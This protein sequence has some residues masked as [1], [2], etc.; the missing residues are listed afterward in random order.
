MPSARARSP[1][2]KT[3]ETIASDSP[4]R[5]APPT[6]CRTRPATSTSSLFD[7]AATTEPPANAAM[8][9]TNT[10]RRPRMSPR[11][12][13][14]TTSAASTSRYAL[15]T[16]CSPAVVV[17]RSRAM[18]G[19]ATLITVESSISTN[20]PMQAPVRVHQRRF[21]S[22][23]P[24][25]APTRAAGTAMAQSSRLPPGSARAVADQ[26]PS[27]A[28]SGASQR[29]SVFLTDD[30]GSGSLPRCRS[31]AR[32]SR[33]QPSSSRLWPHRRPPVHRAPSTRW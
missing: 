27:C 18:S 5:A 20:R 28:S 7:V 25:R 13:A 26:L 10:R 14:L 3:V 1:A 2:G 33:L 16:H 17:S 11:R 12:P 31:V 22:V 4:S 21:D 24:G 23:R 29:S 32:A 15:M 8:P 9:A 19:R 30:C 6:P